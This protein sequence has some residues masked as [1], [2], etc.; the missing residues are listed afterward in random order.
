MAEVEVSTIQKTVRAERS[1]GDFG[2]KQ[3][4]HRPDMWVTD[5]SDIFIEDV[6]ILTIL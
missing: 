3:T 6:K 4:Y 2:H 1:H 5:S